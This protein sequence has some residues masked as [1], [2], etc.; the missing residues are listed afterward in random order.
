MEKNTQFKSPASESNLEITDKKNILYDKYGKIYY[1][2]KDDNNLIALRSPG[3]GAALEKTNDEHIY[4]DGYSGLNVYLTDN[5]KMIP[6]INPMNGKKLTINPD[7]S[8]YDNGHE[9][10][11]DERGVLP[12]FIPDD[13]LEPAHI[14]GDYIVGNETGRRFPIREDGKVIMPFDPIDISP[15]LSA[16]E[17]NAYYEARKRRQ[18][19]ETQEWIDDKIAKDEEENRIA[20]EKAIERMTTEKF[21]NQETR[22]RTK[23]FLNIIDEELNNGW[24]LS[25]EEFDKLDM[26]IKDGKLSDDI[27][28][29]DIGYNPTYWYL[30]NLTEKIKNGGYITEEDKYKLT[31]I[32]K[33]G[34]LPE[35][36]T[37]NHKRK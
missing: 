12:T 16:D 23:R 11:L 28:D 8:Y 33:T 19:N 9:F 7:G 4:H 35:E 18:Y 6:L 27:K 3:S 20:T 25:N 21:G 1:F 30:T 36:K 26:I 14:E 32:L 10:I 37:T 2:K 29:E 17:T 13:T 22:N 34:K 15:N 31:I 24:G 5:G